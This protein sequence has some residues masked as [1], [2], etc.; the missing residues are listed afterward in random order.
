MYKKI[1][2]PVDLAHLGLLEKPLAVAAD[3]AKHYHAAICYVGVTSSQ[4]SQV[5][6]TPEEYAQKLRAFAQEQAPG[7]GDGEQQVETRVYNSPDPIADLDDTLIKAIKE[8]GADLVVMGT[9][10]P[11]RF[12]AIIPANGSKVAARTKASVFLVRP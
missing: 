7:G 8:I 4:P 10:P 9:R 5:A 6:R 3:M 11:K 2:V 12:N 1:M